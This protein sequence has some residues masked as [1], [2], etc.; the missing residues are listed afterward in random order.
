M[1]KRKLSD[2]QKKFAAYYAGGGAK[3]S[4]GGAGAVGRGR[5]QQTSMS[6]GNT[7]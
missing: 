2:D 7:I 3:G 5:S 4:K 1:A 6:F